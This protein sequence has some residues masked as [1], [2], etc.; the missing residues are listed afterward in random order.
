LNDNDVALLLAV[1]GCHKNKTIAGRVR[2][3]KEV[4]LLMYQSKIPFGFN[5]KSY[6]YGPYS[7][8]LFQ[9]INNL[10]SVNLLS[11][12]VVSV[13]YNSYRHDYSLTGQGEKLFKK[14][15]ES[16]MTYLTEIQS[17]I[18]ELE[19]IETPQL[20]LMAKAASGMSSI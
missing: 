19:N 10:V 18:A 3:Q 7:E 11:E 17:K 13:G 16:N 15:C 5:Y 8:D 14:L 2:I 12:T 6:H 4:C 9:V 1:F 20:T